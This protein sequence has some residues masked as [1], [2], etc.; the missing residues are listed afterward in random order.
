MSTDLGLI[1]KIRKA[2]G[3]NEL[4]PLSH[5]DDDARQM[6]AAQSSGLR[7]VVGDRGET[8]DG[9]IAVAA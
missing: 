7:G 9:G 2:L 8:G 6:R 1:Y 3:F 4:Y 5:L